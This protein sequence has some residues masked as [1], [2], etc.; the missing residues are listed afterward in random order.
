MLSV[1]VQLLGGVQR[2]VQLPCTSLQQLVLD[3]V[4]RYSEDIPDHFE[5]RYKDDEDDWIVLHT[6]EDFQES[7]AVAAAAGLLHLRVESA[8][9]E[10]A[11]FQRLKLMRELG[12]GRGG[13][14]SVEPAEHGEGDPQQENPEEREAVSEEGASSSDAGVAAAASSST[15]TST[16]SRP[17]LPTVRP[18]TLDSPEVISAAEREERLAYFQ[19]GNVKERRVKRIEEEFKTF[20]EEWED[21][22]LGYCLW[23][24]SED[25]WGFCIF[26]PEGTPYEGGSFEGVITFSENYPQAPPQVKLT[27]RIFHP[28]IESNPKHHKFGCV[29]VSKL[30]SVADTGTYTPKTTIK[31]IMEDIIAVLTE[32]STRT[33]SSVNFACA[34]LL[35][36]DPEAFA[37]KA[38]LWT[39]RYAAGTM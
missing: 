26:G 17:T 2:R 25:V 3:L 16:S 4:Q 6:E 29:V 22:E 11:R 37:K 33:W 21:G 30:W 19:R 27:T 35:Q 15:S 18:D 20:E 34:Q 36:Q 38:R 10:A 31:E 13:A 24:N 8:E 7:V 9:P 28:S 23:K 14:A 1:K 5:L 32:P 39:Q 12:M